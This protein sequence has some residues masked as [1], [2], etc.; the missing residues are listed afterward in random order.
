[1]P[2][3]RSQRRRGR[4]RGSVAAAREV[5][6][7]AREQIAITS[8]LI[9]ANM[10][11]TAEPHVKEELNHM[12]ARGR[13]GRQ[14]LQ[15]GAATVNGQK[16]FLADSQQIHGSTVKVKAVDAG[17]EWSVEAET[18]MQNKKLQRK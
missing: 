7:G 13:P 8:K 6:A 2:S 12:Q 5:V 14:Q 17:T 9:E 4:T 10:K 11:S 15:K 16:E 3:L 18:Q 1:M